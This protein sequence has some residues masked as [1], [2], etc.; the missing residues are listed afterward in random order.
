MGLDVN[1]TKFLLYARRHGVLFSQTAMIGRQEMHVSPG[2]LAANLNLFGVE[3]TEAAAGKYLGDWENYAEGFFKLL[4]AGEITSFDASPYEKA[5]VLHDFNLPIPDE[6]KG[7]Y[8]AVL[9][10]GTLEHVFN[11]PTAIK[12]CMEMVADGGHFLAITPTNNQLGHGFYQFSPELFYRVFSADNGFEL[13][14]IM[15]FE[16]TPGSSWYRVA[17]PD[18]IRQRV[19][20]ING[21]STMLLI[22]AKKV[23]TV[24]IFARTPQQSDYVAIWTGD[25]AAPKLDKTVSR[26]TGQIVRDIARAPVTAVRRLRVLT[27]RK[28]GMLNRRA[29]HFE[30]VELP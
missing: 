30:K 21:Q 17:D 7:R 13:E 10:G 24:D 16:E 19:E 28:L 18:A 26:S 27:E 12:N 29:K 23:K 9:D 3:T 2:E 15:I 20:L 22:I 14:R 5:T 8:S 25:E 6:F 1:G 11:Y 4:D